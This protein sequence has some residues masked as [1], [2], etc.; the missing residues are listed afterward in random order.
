MPSTELRAA[1]HQAHVATNLEG[2]RM[3][4]PKNGTK[5]KK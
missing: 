4:S 1:G 3:S 2:N 5:C